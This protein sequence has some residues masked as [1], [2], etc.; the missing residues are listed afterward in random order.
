M[1]QSHSGSCSFDVNHHHPLTAALLSLVPGL[2]QLYNGDRRKGIL[3]LDVT[4]VNAVLLWLMLFTEPMLKAMR[5]LSAGFHCRPND[6][7]VESIRYAHIGSPA[8]LLI[9]LLIASFTLFAA[10]DAYDRA[11]KSRTGQ[12]YPGF[13]LEL[14]E[15]C[16][17]SYLL[18]FAC[19]L[20]L[21][22]LAL[23]FLIPR[24]HVTESVD[25][26]FVDT[27]EKHEKTPQTKNA[28]DH[29]TVAHGH[30]DLRKH[31][32][33]SQAQGTVSPST[34]SAPDN[35][36]QSSASTSPAARSQTE[37]E[38][39]T[40]SAPVR[41]SP[42]APERTAPSLPQPKPLEPA[43]NSK[44]HLQP[45]RVEPAHPS[46]APQPRPLTLPS[47]PA[48]VL[49]AHL[50]LLS[51]NT[52]QATVP[53]MPKALRQGVAS[54]MPAPAPVASTFVRSPGAGLPLP[55]APSAHTSIQQGAPGPKA[56]LS[57]L[58]GGA[59]VM[60]AP[61]SAGAGSSAAALPPAPVPVAP[62]SQ[63]K[64]DLPSVLPVTAGSFSQRSSSRNT[65]TQGPEPVKSSG[66][67][68]KTPGNQ[69]LAVGPR[70]AA[71]NDGPTGG[72]SHGRTGSRLP[73]GDRALRGPKEGGEGIN[74]IRD[75][76]NRAPDH[77]SGKADFSRYMAELQRRIK[78]H[79]FPIH[80][81]HSKRVVVI[82]AIHT[83]GVLSDLRLSQS[84]GSREDDKAALDAVTNAA[85]FM[86]LPAHSPESVDIEF[87]FDYNVFGGSGSGG[88]RGTFRQF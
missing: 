33:L 35:T 63:G 70:S 64:S 49:P 34:R 82:F 60:P 47:A 10:R 41:P 14:S 75:T 24:P 31:T 67:E 8:S 61:S 80:G 43:L 23:F 78:R 12:I 19:M 74:P 22:I 25:I 29:N 58:P 59:P 84:S 65:A 52:P 39:K 13:I 44:E 72:K 55:T 66:G 56:I 40:G 62:S 83:D 46:S 27:R 1:S 87:T 73:D 26:Q 11:W 7:V 32:M 68:A 2:G 54:Q 77:D 57:A 9:I 86:S 53:P 88:A 15:A 76:D 81:A 16:S 45:A 21:F 79:W 71:T 69:G 38:Q 51:M 6:C 4:V 36:R 50:P 17:G 28:S 37:A 85:P 42:H 48:N 3:F 30:R 5:E 20:S 18:H